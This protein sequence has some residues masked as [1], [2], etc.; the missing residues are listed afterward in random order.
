MDVLN[1]GIRLFREDDPILGFLEKFD[2]YVQPIIPLYI[3]VYLSEF[4]TSMKALIRTF[5][6]KTCNRNYCKGSNRSLLVIKFLW[7]LYL[8]IVLV[9]SP[10][11]VV[12]PQV[13]AVIVA[14][15]ILYIGALR[16]AAACFNALTLTSVSVSL[17]R[18]LQILY[19][20]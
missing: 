14:S 17:Q 10:R 3:Y 5:T 7:L 13:I 11:H 1:Q 18:P 6:E 4:S 9:S 20:Q 8:P 2:H 16:T 19:K 12:L 15:V